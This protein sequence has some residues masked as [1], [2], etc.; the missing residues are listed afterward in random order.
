[1]YLSVV[2]IVVGQGVLLSQGILVAYG[3]LIWIVEHGFVR[4]YEERRLQTSFDAD[5]ETYCRQVHRWLPR[6]PAWRG[7]TKD[8]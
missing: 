6:W 7:D 2:A 4:I 3:L 5:Y 1:M 8:G